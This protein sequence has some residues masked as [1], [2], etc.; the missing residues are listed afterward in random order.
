MVVQ[1]PKV[2]H[3]KSDPDTLQGFGRDPLVC[4]PASLG[5]T[6]VEESLRG[7]DYTPNLVEDSLRLRAAWDYTPNLVEDSL[8][9]RAL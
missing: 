8:R 1:T 6:L 7:L 9:L 3:Q 5:Y 4:L 2:V